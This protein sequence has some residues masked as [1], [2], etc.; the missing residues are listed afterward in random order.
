LLGPP[1]PFAARSSADWNLSGDLKSDIKDHV[2]GI[3]TTARC[4]SLPLPLCPSLSLALLVLH[5]CFG[6]QVLTLSAPWYL[7]VD[8]TLVWY[9]APPAPPLVGLVLFGT[10]IVGNETRILQREG[11]S[12]TMNGCVWEQGGG[13]PWG[14]RMSVF[15]RTLSCAGY[16]ASRGVIASPSFGEQFFGRF[17]LARLPPWLALPWTSLRPPPLAAGA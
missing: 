4:Q 15:R 2:R 12:Y 9:N 5:H 14:S 10:L 8:S 6:V 17:P 3:S 13:C 1:F 16:T 11:V 7:P